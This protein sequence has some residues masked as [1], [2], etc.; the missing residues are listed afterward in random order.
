MR[1]SNFFSFLLLA[2]LIVP[3]LAGAAW[4][5]K[6]KSYYN[7]DSYQTMWVNVDALNIRS[8]P[9]THCRVEDVLY[10]GNTA[11]LI[12]E[13]GGW[14][15]LLLSNGN[16]GWAS[17]SYLSSRPVATYAPEPEVVRPVEV[18]PPTE[19]IPPVVEPGSTHD[20]NVLYLDD[21][22]EIRDDRGPH[23]DNTDVNDIFN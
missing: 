15:K 13:K 12:G 10:R 16:K 19:V 11:K 20:E 22:T 18:V 3:S 2:I 9:D 21:L 7:T 6:S 17:S 14:Y 23:S 8:C 4:W 5:P 1:R